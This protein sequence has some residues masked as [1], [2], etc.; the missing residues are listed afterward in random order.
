MFCLLN[1]LW[2]QDMHFSQYYLSPLTLNP[3]N[4]G[5]YRG[6]YRFFGNYRS[7]WRD[8]D[9][10]YNT[11]TAGGDL[12]MYP[13]NFNISPGI[14]FMSDKSS[15]NLNVTKVIP[16]FAIHLKPGGFK[17]HL[18]VQPAVVFKSID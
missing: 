7:Q 5:N 2:S 18:G 17:I 14:L 10:G 13:N 11:F 8:L 12:N 4:T 9:K 1:I 3:A 16:S 15:L 6:D